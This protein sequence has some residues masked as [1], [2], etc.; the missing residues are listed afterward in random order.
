V[1]APVEKAREIDLPGRDLA[2]VKLPRSRT[3]WLRDVAYAI[4]RDSVRGR[5]F[6]GAGDW[7]TSPILWDEL[8]S[9]HHEAEFFTRTSADG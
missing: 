5:R 8:H 6:L 3:T 1:Y 9:T 4:C 7:N 2:T